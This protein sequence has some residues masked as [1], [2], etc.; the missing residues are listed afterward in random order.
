MYYFI[1]VVVV[2]VLVVV[3]VVVVVVAVIVV[4]VVIISGGGGWWGRPRGGIGNSSVIDG[5]LGNSGYTGTTN[6]EAACIYLPV[7]P[8]RV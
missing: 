6:V 8:Y 7:G 1:V 4:V 2:V 3:V 5:S